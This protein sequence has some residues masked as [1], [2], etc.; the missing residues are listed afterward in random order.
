VKVKEVLR[1]IHILGYTLENPIE[2][3]GNISKKNV[4]IWRLENPQ[5][6]KKKKG[7]FHFELLFFSHL[8]KFSQKQ[9]AGA[10][11]WYFLLKIFGVFRRKK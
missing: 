10:K 9:K 1:F 4:Q 6:K 3:S 11:S 2:K 7:I 5:K 8:V